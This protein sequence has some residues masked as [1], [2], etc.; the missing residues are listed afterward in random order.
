MHDEQSHER[1]EL[2]TRVAREL[3]AAPLGDGAAAKARIAAAVL[4]E[5]ATDGAHHGAHHDAH[6]GARHAGRD[7]ARGGGRIAAAWRWVASPRAVR[8][9][10]LGALAAAAGLVAV[11]WTLSS[12]ATLPPHA[13]VAAERGALASLGAASAPVPG[14]VTDASLAA[15]S[16]AHALAHAAGAERP[17]VVQFVFVAPAARRVA[18]VGD[19]NGWDARSTP[20]QRASGARGDVWAVELTLMPGRHAYAFIVDDSTWVADPGAARAPGDDFGTPSSVI[21]VGAGAT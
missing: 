14:S 3:R 2:I 7:G 4:R 13:K 15:S 12:R 1:D 18:L 21:V 20:L 8:V 16:A 17:R 19:F 5:G 9:S 6:H 11:A 10:P